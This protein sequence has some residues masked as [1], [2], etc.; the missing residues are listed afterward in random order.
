M[1]TRTGLVQEEYNVF[2]QA[3][4]LAKRGFL[5]VTNNLQ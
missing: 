1:Y 4:I 2:S 5:N 3:T